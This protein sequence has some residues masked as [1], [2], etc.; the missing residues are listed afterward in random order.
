MSASGGMAGAWISAQECAIL[1]AM[2]VSPKPP[3]WRPPSPLPQHFQTERLVLRYFMPEDAESLL[4]ALGVDRA[5]LVP[6]MPWALTDNRTPP[7]TY[8]T[9]ER[10]RRDRERTDPP[11]DNF[12]IGMF[13][14]AT[15]D[16][17]GGPGFH[18]MAIE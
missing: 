18:R 14:R 1:C 15:N 8:F 12:L 10:A 3:P 4:A 9:I 16:V 13:D 17:I 5:S 2:T 7:E 6:W 11:A